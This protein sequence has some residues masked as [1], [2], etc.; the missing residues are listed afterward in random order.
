MLVEHIQ[1][2][3]EKEIYITSEEGGSWLKDVR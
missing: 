2:G 3:L 1:A